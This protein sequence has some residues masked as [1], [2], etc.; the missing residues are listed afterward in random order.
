MSLVVLEHHPDETACVLARILQG[1]GHRLRTVRLHAGEQVPVDLD[2]VDGLL[3]LGGPM[4][5]GETERHPWL[6]GEI[7]L[8]RRGHEA[9]LPILGLCLGAQLLAVALGGK[10]APM[11]KPEV[12]FGTVRLAF[13]GTIDPLLSGAPWDTAQFH[14][15]GQQVTELPERATPLASSPSCRTQAFRAGQTSYAFQ[16]HFEWDRPTIEHMA[17]GPAV[18]AA[19]L[20]A[21]AVQEQCDTH[22][23]RYR[24][25]GDRLC[26]NIAALLFR[27]GRH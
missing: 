7:D 3:S 18:A 26:D 21:Q 17:T 25:L 5:V 6:T 22:Y 13:P 16:Y 11:A 19:G 24:H 23:E 4:N 20:S 1:H 14:L 12:G 15:H 10:V 9:G 8:L 2:D 27:S